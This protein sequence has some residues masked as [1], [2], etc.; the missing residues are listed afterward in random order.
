MRG[1]LVG[2]WIKTNTNGPM[3]TLNMLWWRWKECLSVQGVM[4][5]GQ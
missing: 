3:V 4:V 1:T 2:R 5:K